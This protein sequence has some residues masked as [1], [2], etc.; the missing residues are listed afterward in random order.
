M[1]VHPVLHP[2]SPIPFFEKSKPSEGGAGA[3]TRVYGH[4]L[5]L[6]VKSEIKIPTYVLQIKSDEE[7][8][9]LSLSLSLSTMS[10]RRK[11]ATQPGMYFQNIICLD[12]LLQGGIH[13]IFRLRFVPRKVPLY[14]EF[15]HQFLQNFR[16]RRGNKRD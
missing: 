12:R 9:Q 1:C 6:N 4:I 8:P 11:N 15:H 14:S 13:W 10:R 16:A 3:G 5:N 7:I 2:T